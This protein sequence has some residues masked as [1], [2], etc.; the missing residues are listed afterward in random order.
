MRQQMKLHTAR[1]I[2]TNEHGIRLGEAELTE[3]TPNE[4]KYWLKQ[5][6]IF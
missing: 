1:D 4:V 2:L 3:A 6:T 5:K